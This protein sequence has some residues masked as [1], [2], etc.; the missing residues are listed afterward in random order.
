MT[1][2]QLIEKLIANGLLTND[3]SVK[4]LS[5]AALAKKSA[6]ALLYEQNLIDE[7]AIAKAKSQLLG[8]P[9]QRVNLNQI[10]DDVLKLVPAEMVMNFK[11]VPLAKQGN[12]LV[13][14]MVHPDDRAAQEALRFLAQQNKISLGVYLITPSD[15]EL[16]MRRYSPFSD[17]VA[18]ALKLLNIKP[19]K[20]GTAGARMVQLDEGAS[21]SEE[22]PI[23]KIV[24]SL[25]KEAVNIKASDV[26]IEPQRNRV[27]VRFRVDGVLHDQTSLPIELQQPVISRV[28]VLSNLKIDENRVP[29]D[30]RFRTLIFNR[31]I[32]FRVSTFP[33]PAGEKV[34]IRVL[35][36]NVGLK[37]LDELGLVGH[38]LETVQQAIQK[39]FGM[40]LL[41]GPTGSGKTTTLYA[42][43]Q[44]LNKDDVNIVSLE[45]PVEYTID[46]VNQSQV[47][48]EI[49]YD[50]ASGLR[51][52]LRQ[53]PD[54]VMVGEIRDG[55]TAGLAVNAALTGHIVL[56]TL[57]TNN[58]IGVIPRLL[59]LKVDAFLLPS[60]LNLM[61]AQRLVSR[62]CDKCK[63]AE[64]P[65]KELLGI[66]NK[67][68]GGRVSTDVKIYHAA[69]CAACNN[70]GVI[71]RVALFEVFA[72]TPQLTEIISAQVNE[73]KLIE[74]AKRQGMVT[75]RQDGIAKALTGLVS[76]EEVL[77]ET[78]EGAS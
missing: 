34:A 78:N 54:V 23:I 45:D 33:T 32:D 1:D 56:S 50:F 29:Q 60:S 57:H 67:E 21:V 14:G 73:N 77:R 52:I 20:D 12:M 41:S 69:G 76:I 30:G 71:G 58:A 9:V 18:V 2:K 68:L 35:D 59:D 28:K 38:N 13:V 19:R 64:T 75:M 39:P 6:E 47:R 62:L 25:L 5:E 43:M 61:I 27:R 8:I 53:D 42:L 49:G 70:K 40:V 10:T 46:G 66:I 24:S 44:L 48:P 11:V 16:I 55:E 51:Q 65:S 31:D 15:L 37:K 26:H 74:E 63:R 22:A 7:M 17:E 4:I 72:M 3:Q 36:P